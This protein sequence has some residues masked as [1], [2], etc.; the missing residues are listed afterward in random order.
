MC[1]YIY[2]YKIT[3][4]P[5]RYT[6]ID[7]YPKYIIPVAKPVRPPV[8]YWHPCFCGVAS[9]LYYMTV[10][11]YIVELSLSLIRKLL[12]SIKRIFKN[13]GSMVLNL[14]NLSCT[15]VIIGR[16]N[17]LRI[18]FVI[19]SVSCLLLEWMYKIIWF[20]SFFFFFWN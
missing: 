9:G 17:Y 15:M 7:R 13:V 3:V 16:A 10:S 5:K 4:N 14:L 6:S 11:L 19:S 18:S 1:V 12:M 2:I 20:H 8:R